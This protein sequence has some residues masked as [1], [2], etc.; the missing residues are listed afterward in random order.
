MSYDYQ[1]GGYPTSNFNAKKGVIEYY[2]APAAMWKGFENLTI[3]LTLDEDMPIISRSTL[4]FKKISD[5][6]YQ[7][8]S[9]SLPETN[10]EI[11]IDE[12][13]IQNIFSTFRSP[14]LLMTIRMFL[15]YLL[16]VVVIIAVIV[17]LIKRKR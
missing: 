1:L 2:L 17:F 5:R 10:L 3:N 13:W 15:P 7:Y 12:N 16:I 4:E 11:V 6:T 9:N 8:V 14:Y